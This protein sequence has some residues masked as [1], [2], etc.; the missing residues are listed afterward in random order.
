MSAACFA[1][2]P[3]KLIGD[4]SSAGVGQLDMAKKKKGQSREPG[5]KG[6]SALFLLSED[7]PLRKITRFIIE[8]PPFEFMVLVTII[9]NCVVLALEEHLPKGDRTPLAQKLVR[10][11]RSSSSSRQEP[12]LLHIRRNIACGE[13]PY[14]AHA[15]RAD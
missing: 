1:N 13:M 8:W 5:E 11:L 10:I 2:S 3:S 6:P 4:I 7:H 15:A 12:F 14:P 9:A